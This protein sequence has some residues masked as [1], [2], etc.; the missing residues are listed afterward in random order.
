[1][2]SKP[3]KNERRHSAP[4]PVTTA[5]TAQQ[6]RNT[7]NAVISSVLQQAVPP[8]QEAEEKMETAS[9]GTAA[10]PMQTS[11]SG[12]AGSGSSE[13]TQE[14]SGTAATSRPP[15]AAKAVYR[16][17]HSQ[18][19]GV[20][21]IGS[22]NIGGTAN[23]SILTTSR[24]KNIQTQRQLRGEHTPIGSGPAA[25]S[26]KCGDIFLNGDSRNNLAVLFKDNREL[27]VTTCSFIHEDWT[28]IS[29]SNSHPLLPKISEKE[30]WS[31]GRKLIFLTDHNMPA[32]LP[33]LDGKCPIIVRMDGGL[34]REIGTNFLARLRGYSIP[35]GSVVV[36]GSVTHL[37]EEGRVGYSKGLVTEFIRLTKA[38][39]GTIH[40][41][42]FLPP[43]PGGGRMIRNSSV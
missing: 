43:P 9:S 1:M 20:S 35:E 14:G 38:F 7:A 41:V 37:M 17:Y 40:V 42:P 36:I 3:G 34:L 29:C 21:N 18:E 19:Y 25:D 12:T 23:N 27:M 11:G 31:G 2:M 26:F 39:K 33:S 15:A 13:P 16:N 4:L 32:V 22:G 24:Y 8:R 10:V 28:C 5:A 30:L 6:A